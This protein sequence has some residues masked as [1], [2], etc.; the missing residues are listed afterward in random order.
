MREH[1]LTKPIEIVRHRLGKQEVWEVLAS[2]QFASDIWVEWLFDW[3]ERSHH[4]PE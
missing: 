1:E 4:V 2:F 3:I